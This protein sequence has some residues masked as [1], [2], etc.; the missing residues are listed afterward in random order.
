VR[1]AIRQQMMRQVRADRAAKLYAAALA[2]VP[3]TV[4]EAAV[5]AMEA[6]QESAVGLTAVG[7]PPK[8]S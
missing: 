1:D 7:A 2:N 5:A 3:V 8:G 6:A 4:S